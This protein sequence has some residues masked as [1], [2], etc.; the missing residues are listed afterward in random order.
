M[1]VKGSSLACHGQ[2]LWAMR[3]NTAQLNMSRFKQAGLNQ[4][5]AQDMYLM[6][7]SDVKERQGKKNALP[8]SFCCHCLSIGSFSEANLN[9]LVDYYVLKTGMWN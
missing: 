3:F 7:T 6:L 4:G 5:D 8:L 9:I 2:L 1:C